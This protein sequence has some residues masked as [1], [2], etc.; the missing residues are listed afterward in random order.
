MKNIFTYALRLLLVPVLLINF[1]SCENETINN[2][3]PQEGKVIIEYFDEY[4][5]STTGIHYLDLVTDKEVPA[6]ATRDDDRPVSLGGP[7]GPTLCPYEDCDTALPAMSATLQALA[8]EQC[9]EIWYCVACCMDGYIVYA[10]M[11][12]IPQSPPCPPRE[13]RIHVPVG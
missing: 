8:N 1:T 10:M 6:A 2:V 9:Q 13:V 11:Y 3:E 7:V 4:Q 5:A 12:A